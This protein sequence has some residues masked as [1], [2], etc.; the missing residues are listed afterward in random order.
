MIMKKT[1]KSEKCIRKCCKG[2]SKTAGGYHWKY[3]EEEDD[4]ISIKG[5]L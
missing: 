1:E 5:K 2:E 4:S 3:V